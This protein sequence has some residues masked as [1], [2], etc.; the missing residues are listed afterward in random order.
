MKTL[1]LVM[2]VLESGT[3]LALLKLAAV[4]RGFRAC[5]ALV[6]RLMPHWLVANML[7]G[8]C[9][10]CLGRCLLAGASCGRA[11]QAHG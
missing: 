8:T 1:L 5:S 9:T 2:A 3:G 10:F 6:K 4:G 7:A 11:R